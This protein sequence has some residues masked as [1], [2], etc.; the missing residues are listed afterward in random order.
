MK[1][2]LLYTF[3]IILTLVVA[4][5]GILYLLKVTAETVVETID[6]VYDVKNYTVYIDDCVRYT[7]ASV[8]PSDTYG[9][10]ELESKADRKIEEYA[11]SYDDVDQPS[12]K[13]ALEKL[14]KEGNSFEKKYATNLLKIYNGLKIDLTPFEKDKEK[15]Y[16]YRFMEK[17]SR[18]HFTASVGVLCLFDA[19]IWD[20]GRYAEYLETGVFENAPATSY[21]ETDDEELGRGDEVDEDIEYDPVVDLIHARIC[22]QY[23]G[24]YSDDKIMSKAFYSIFR[25]AQ[26]SDDSEVGWPD[27]DYWHCTQGAEAKL[28]SIEVEKK[29]E[30]SAIAHVVLF[31]SEL[32]EYKSVDMPMVYENGNWFVDDII[33]YEGDTRYSLKEAAK[34]KSN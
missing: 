33:S 9:S 29:T 27:W 26:Q 12:Y 11:S 31:Y 5:G 6:D 20:L 13:L 3:I 25:K 21:D 19:D 17:N 18:V 23:N 14:S 1:K 4:A 32:D 16:K 34:K 10:T 28:S 8:H 7:L 2:F 24:W 22:D 15:D 30:T